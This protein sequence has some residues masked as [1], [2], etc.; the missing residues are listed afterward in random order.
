MVAARTAPVLAGVEQYSAL[1][2][3]W[4]GKSHAGDECP[5]QG[6][7]ALIDRGGEPASC[8]IAAARALGADVPLSRRNAILGV[9]P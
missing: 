9:G 2:E 7:A 4:N 1:V 8:P 5:G 3:Q 6:L